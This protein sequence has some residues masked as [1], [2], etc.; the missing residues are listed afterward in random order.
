MQ[1]C[2]RLDEEAPGKA[3]LGERE[4]GFAAVRPRLAMGAGWPG[5]AGGRR[6]RCGRSSR[7]RSQR[8]GP[9][10]C[11]EFADQRG[12]ALVVLEHGECLLRLRGAVGVLSGVGAA[13]QAGTA[14]P[15]STPRSRARTRRGRGGGMAREQHPAAL[16]VNRRG[17]PGVPGNAGRG[18]PARHLSTLMKV[19][20]TV[21]L[22]LTMLGVVGVLFAGLIGLARGGSDTT[23]NPGRSN[24][25]MRWRVVLQ[26]AALVVFVILLTLLRHA[27]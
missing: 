7:G 13:A 16:Q 21:L 14:K 11:L 3:V 23:G 10:D 17:S 25:L 4:Q 24:Q 5:R 19:L 27:S 9:G 2:R 6:W 18:I 1:L 26:A 15:A 20:L 22:G 8:L 12:P